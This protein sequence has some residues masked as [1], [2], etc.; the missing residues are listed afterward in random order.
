MKSLS[1]DLYRKLC[2]ILQEIRLDNQNNTSGLKIHKSVQLMFFTIFNEV[3]GVCFELLK[4]RIDLSH[5]LNSI[6]MALLCIL[7]Q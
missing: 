4:L 7:I 6:E 5:V 2:V 3:T 1:E